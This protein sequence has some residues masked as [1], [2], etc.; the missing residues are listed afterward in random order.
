MTSRH[1]PGDILFLQAGYFIFS[2]GGLSLKFASSFS[3]NEAK[4]YLYYA[5]GLLFM[6]VFAVLWQQILKTWDLT[7]AYAWRCV[8]FFWS[9][10]WAVL[11]FGETI[12]ARNVFGAA[13]I[14]L[15]IIMVNR[16]E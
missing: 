6:M 12:T 9:F 8:G 10:L 14:V 11:F 15:G 1:S 5:G 2:L 7:H 16:S 4:F 13:I 3:V